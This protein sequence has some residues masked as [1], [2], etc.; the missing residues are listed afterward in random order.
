MAN[1]MTAFSRVEHCGDGYSL[2]WELRSVNHR[3]LDVSLKLPDELR[4]LDPDCRSAISNQIARGRIDAMLK[5]ERLAD[6]QGNVE[7]DAEAA[8][9]VV[10]ALDR[11]AQLSERL[12]PASTVDILRWPGVISEREVDSGAMGDAALQALE[13]AI[14]ELCQNR[15]R[16]GER[17]VAVIHEKTNQCAAIAGALTARF[18]DIQ[19]KV[20]DKWESRI[21]DLEA[22]VEP[23]RLAQEIAL[24]LT[25]SDITEELD[26]LNTHL[27][28]T[29]SL[30]GAEK[31]VGRSLDFLMQELNREANTLGSK[32]VDEEMTNASIELKVL[33]D[34]IREQVQNLE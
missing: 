15:A 4:R 20:R 1:S 31:P 14:R 21:A 13:N 18:P 22:R 7:F 33:I 3:Y 6:S 11:I 34:Q 23:E 17:L 25:K 32:S 26:R 5:V 30:L 9:N 8:G 12:R 10:A 2:V 19:R 27:E 29:G 28:E 24:I 16:E